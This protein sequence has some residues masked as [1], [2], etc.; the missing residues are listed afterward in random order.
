MVPNEEVPSPPPEVHLPVEEDSLTS[1]LVA[2]I[3]L[4]PEH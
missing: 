1:Y 4:T 2:H 3:T